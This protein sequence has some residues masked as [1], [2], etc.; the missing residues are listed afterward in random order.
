MENKYCVIVDGYSTGNLLPA[1][2]KA[3]GFSP[4]HV[5]STPVI[6]P[7]LTLTYRPQDYERRLA[8]AGDLGPLLLELTPLRPA[9]VVPGTET[10]V[11][12]ADQLSEALGAASNGTRMSEARRNKFLMIE[13]VRKAGLKTARQI[14]SRDVGE[15]LRWAADGGLTKVV[16]KPLKSA[17]T[18]SVAVCASPGEIESACRRILGQTNQLGLMNEDVLC[19][20]FLEG[21]EYAIDAV[22]RCGQAH[23]TAIW[24]YHKIA[25]DNS[26]FIERD[27][28][29]SCTDWAGSTLCEYVR[30]VLKALEIEHGPS[31][32]EV[33]MTQGGPALVEIGARLNGLTAPGLYER[34]V[35]YGQLDMTA[36]C[37]LNPERFR[38]K[39]VSPYEL[40][41]HALSIALISEREG[42]VK[43][44]P[45][46]ELL[47]ELASFSELRMRA[48]PGYRLKRSIDFYT[49]PGFVIL[50]HPDNNVIQADLARIRAF[51]KEGRLYELEAQ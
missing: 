43:S 26:P 39:S 48:K 20:E 37:F 6:W 34:C 7:L 49:V 35:G 22:S 8:F 42:T 31:H 4:I 14:K 36:D 40:K 33:M 24:R 5:Q 19:Q 3:R 12:L 2:F 21:T 16:V 46:E 18:D 51:E 45:G 50:V 44:V 13:A 15:I 38:E 9:C 47:R 1:E 29:V 25:V 17:G 27:E 11:E 32:T 23:I 30:N 41:Q 10:G 28:L